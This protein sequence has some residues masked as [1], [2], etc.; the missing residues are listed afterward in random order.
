MYEIRMLY[1]YI[2]ARVWCSA[3][4]RLDKEEDV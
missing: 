3:R 2:R 1:E 4:A